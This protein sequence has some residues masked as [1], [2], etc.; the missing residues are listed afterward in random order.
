[1]NFSSSFE[2]ESGLALYVIVFLMH[3]QLAH[4]ISNNALD[5]IFKFFKNVLMLLNDSKKKL[6]LDVF[7]Q[8]F[9]PSLY[10]AQ[11]H[12]K[13][14]SAPFQEFPVCP[15]CKSV[16]SL[17]ECIETHGS[18]RRS[19]PCKKKIGSTFCN[20][21]V[22]TTHATAH[23]TIF[24]PIQTFCYNSITMSL[25]L[26]IQNDAS[27]LTRCNAW[28]NDLAQH[29]SDLLIDVF[30]GA[31][32]RDVL[33]VVNEPN[34]LVLQLNIDWFQPFEHVVYS[35]GV[36]YLS[37]LNLP[38]PER[39]K[40]K[41]IFLLGVIPGPDEPRHD[42]NSFLRPLVDELLVLVDK[43]IEVQHQNGTVNLK[44]V[45]GCVACDIPASRKVSGFIGH[46]ARL[47]CSR[48]KKEFKYDKQTGKMDYS[49]FDRS[50][51]PQRTNHQHRKDVE[52]VLACKTKTAREQKESELGCRYS[53]LLDLPYFD[54]VRMTVIDPMHNLFLGTAK[55]FMVVL[56]EMGKVSKDNL[57]IIQTT[58]DSVM[59]PQGVSKIPKKIQSGFSRLTAEQWKNWTLVYSLIAL[60]PFV[61]KEILECWRHFVLACRYIVQHDLSQVD[62]QIADALF[63]RF[64][65]KFQALLGTEHVTPNIHLNAHLTEC[66][67]DYGPL[68]SFWLFAFE[69][70]NGILGAQKTNNSNIE[71]QLMRK[72]LREAEIAAVNLPE[73]FHNELHHFLPHVGLKDSKVHLPLKS[74]KELLPLQDIALLKKFL[75]II[76]GIND[77]DVDVNTSVEKY[78]YV[79]IKN[80]KFGSENDLRHSKTVVLAN[81]MVALYG[82]PPSLVLSDQQ[83]LQN[84]DSCL[85]A[86]F[87]NAYYNI[88][89]TVI[90]DHER[91]TQKAL[92]AKGTWPKYSNHGMYY[93]KPYTVWCSDLVETGCSL[94]P[95]V[96]VDEIVH[97]CAYY[98]STISNIGVLCVC[99]IIN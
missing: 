3:L 99:P 2:S 76:N 22:V 73:T 75:G 20:S 14:H 29:D 33:S 18:I 51:W 13:T 86:F 26:R 82:R 74:S 44:C 24:R 1:M 93:G 41:N 80:R 97:N 27:F 23:G 92:I 39:Y 90:T 95:F 66:T 46:S 31:M 94:S 43:G 7:Y 36:M 30:D 67:K 96:M 58:V 70:Y 98:T 35:V 11:R 84:H 81:W 32:W 91:R 34:C 6:S 69:R 9:P 63:L 72:F 38:S 61:S 60:K 83:S 87:V 68:R 88:E 42:I 37:V 62:L 25:L 10:V 49:G 78:S 17:D 52:T 53:A 48:C 4:G 8:V 21:E 79:I 71:P 45:L 50:N 77:C 55:R 89:Y 19:K 15:R 54:P 57:V 12:I 28:K 59:V 65:T 85:R 40:V 64:C 5:A 16:Y 47:G 56:L